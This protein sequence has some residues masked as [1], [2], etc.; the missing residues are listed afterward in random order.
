MIQLEK[1]SVVIERHYGQP[2][3]IE[4]AKDGAWGDYSSSR[5]ARDCSGA[6]QE[7]HPDL[8]VRA[9]PPHHLPAEQPSE[10]PS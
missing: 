7:C 9:A 4:W 10:T 3:D 5:P 1:W 6:S 2:M 8:Q